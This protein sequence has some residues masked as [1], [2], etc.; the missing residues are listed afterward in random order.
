M[1]SHSLLLIS[2]SKS[3]QTHAVSIRKHLGQH[4]VLGTIKWLLG[5]L[6][7]SRWRS[8]VFYED[9]SV[10][11]SLAQWPDGYQYSPPVSLSKI[12]ADQ[13][14][15]LVDAG[16]EETIRVIGLDDEVYWITWK[17]VVVSAG[18][19]LHGSP[20]CS[21]L[22]LPEKSILIGHCIT[23]EDHRRKSLYSSAISNTI[24]YLRNRG[25]CSIFMETRLDN[26][27]S[28]RGILKAGLKHWKIVDARIL[29][30]SIVF[31]NNSLYFLCR[32]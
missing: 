7:Y 1:P 5:K 26:I 8:L 32:H 28:Q 9:L 10:E 6:F 11:R 3:F 25:N 23:S 30:R 24:H 21:I 15:Q 12:T 4:G 29:F 22:G 20:Q 16:F 17:N 31:R 19:V 14:I 18:V 13:K 2:M 27:A